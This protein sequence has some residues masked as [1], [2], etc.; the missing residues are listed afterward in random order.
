ML[1]RS[2]RYLYDRVCCS[3]E[4]MSFLY[5]PSPSGPPWLQDVYENVV[6]RWIASG[7]LL[8]QA[9]DVARSWKARVCGCEM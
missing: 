6:M 4:I 7:C 5:W 3:H 1:R 9:W 8:T 2:S